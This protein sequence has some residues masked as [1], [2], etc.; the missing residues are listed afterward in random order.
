MHFNVR[1]SV[2]QGR[3]L[4]GMPL[5][6]SSPALLSFSGAPIDDARRLSVGASA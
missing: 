2:L 5:R 3:M 1:A 4:E 6:R